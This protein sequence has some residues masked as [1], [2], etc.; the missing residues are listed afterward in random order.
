MNQREGRRKTPVGAVEKEIKTS[1]LQE[2]NW[3]L[4]R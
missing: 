3:G 1:E 2:N 4:E